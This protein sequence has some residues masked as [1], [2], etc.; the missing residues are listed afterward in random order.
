MSRRWSCIPCR[1]ANDTGDDD[2]Y[3]R[4]KDVTAEVIA[5]YNEEYGTALR[6]TGREGD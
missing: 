3:F 6:F 5:E 1:I 2:G 4:Y